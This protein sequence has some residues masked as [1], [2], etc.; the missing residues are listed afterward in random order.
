MF[1]EVSSPIYREWST[2]EGIIFIII[3][4]IMISVLPRTLA[5]IKLIYFSLII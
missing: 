3:V 5:D 4:I 1:R 2:K